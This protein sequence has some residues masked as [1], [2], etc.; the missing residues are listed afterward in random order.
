MNRHKHCGYSSDSVVEE[1]IPPSDSD[2]E[3]KVYLEDVLPKLGKKDLDFT[4]V[5]TF[6]TSENPVNKKLNSIRIPEDSGPFDQMTRDHVLKSQFANMYLREYTCHPN[7]SSEPNP[8]VSDF[9]T[10]SDLTEEQKQTTLLEVM[11]YLAHIIQ[12]TCLMAINDNNY[13]SKEWHEC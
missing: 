2:G 12:C 9:A 1:I 5:F 7:G 3:E 6:G 4:K 10:T 13:T 11:V 8:T